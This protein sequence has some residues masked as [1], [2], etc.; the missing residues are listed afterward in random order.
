MLSAG[1]NAGGLLLADNTTT[2][3]PDYNYPETWLLS[4]KLFVTPARFWLRCHDGKHY[5]ELTLDSLRLTM[6]A[7]S[8]HTCAGYFRYRLNLDE[9]ERDF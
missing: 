4:V 5:A 8:S 7:D 3:A 9:G 1:L 6:Q 2:W